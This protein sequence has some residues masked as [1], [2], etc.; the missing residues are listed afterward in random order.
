[1]SNLTYLF[2]FA[3]IFSLAA[4]FLTTIFIIATI[5]IGIF[6]VVPI[7]LLLCIFVNDIVRG[8]FRNPR[9]FFLLL[10][11]RGWRA[12]GARQRE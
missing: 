3:L 5:G 1:M 2:F 4:I 10:L 8:G 7:L 11:L 9:I 6:T 12:R